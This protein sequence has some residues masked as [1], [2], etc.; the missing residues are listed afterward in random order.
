MNQ[1][2]KQQFGLPENTEMTEPLKIYL[3]E[4]SQIP[5]LGEDEEKE[6]AEKCSRGDELAR[7]KLEE[8]NLRLVV[9]LAKNFADRGVALMDLIQEGNIGLMRAA[10]EYDG[11]TEESFSEYAVERIE[12]AMENAVSEQEMEI[13]VPA[14]VAENMQKVQKIRAQLKEELGREATTEEIAERMGDKTTD[15]VGS[16]LSYLDHPSGDPQEEQEEEKEDSTPEDAMNIL[17]QKEEVSELLSALDEK[18]NRVIR[19]RFGLEGGK[20]H[21]PEE[22]AEILQIT[23][24]EARRMEAEAM[25][26]LRENAGADA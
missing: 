2:I 13:K 18:E 3:G 1:D 8:A 10:E 12:E 23:E 7:M 19:L 16:I 15:E 24:E 9:S 4:I 25:K 5:V 11:S 20:A 21:A 14:Y 17:V 6:L 26:K 22:V